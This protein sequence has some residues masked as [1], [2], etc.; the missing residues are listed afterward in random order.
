MI[1]IIIIMART[2]QLPTAFK[3]NKVGHATNGTRPV[4]SGGHTTRLR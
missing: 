1:I 2:D 3:V 4:V